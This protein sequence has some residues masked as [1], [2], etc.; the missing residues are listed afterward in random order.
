MDNH[1]LHKLWEAKARELV[2]QGYQRQDYPNPSVP[3]TFHK[4]RRV[5]MLVRNLG[6]EKW[7]TR[8][9]KRAS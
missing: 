7:Y 4:D 1:H 6:G 5:F 8:E 2:L 3:S 9:I